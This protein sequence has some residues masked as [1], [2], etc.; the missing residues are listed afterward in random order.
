M[1]TLSRLQD[2]Y[3]GQ[4][5]GDWE[6]SLGIRIESCDN[7]GWWVKINLAGTRLLGLQFVEIAEGVDSR[8]HPIESRWLD[9]H[10]EDAVWHG[11]GDDT[12]LERILEEFLAW[13]ENAQ[14]R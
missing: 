13:A 3:A 11:A 4:C 5:N 9:C 12:K 7:P 6:H 1:S 2:W 10:V 14:D 8:R